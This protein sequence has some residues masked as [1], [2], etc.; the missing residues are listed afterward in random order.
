MKRSHRSLWGALV[1]GLAIMSASAHAGERSAPPGWDLAGSS[2]T[3]FEIEVEPDAGESVATLRSTSDPET[4]FG[5]MMQTMSARDYRAKRVRLSA[6]VA[7]DL[8]RGWAGLWMRVDGQRRQILGFDNMNGRPLVGRS[9][10]ARHE[11]VLDV[12][13]EAEA[14]AFG[15]LLVGEGDVKLRAVQFEIVD[16]STPVTAR[17][18]NANGPVNLGFES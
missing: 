7:T 18:R 16:G 3:S 6:A 17:S 1:G 5:T 13:L 9:S 10:F 12:P 14:I 4:G 15:V 2:P 11:V 8:E